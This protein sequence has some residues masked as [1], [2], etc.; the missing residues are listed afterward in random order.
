LLRSLSANALLILTY[1]SI[2]SEKEVKTV[3]NAVAQARF[4]EQMGW[5]S[6]QYRCVTL[7]EAFDEWIQFG[8]INPRT[9]VVTFDDGFANNYENG[10]PILKEF[11]IRA[12]FFVTTG[13]LGTNSLPILT[14]ARILLQVAGQR[15]I[16]LNSND[17]E[18]TYQRL[19][20]A[21]KQE[22]KEIV[23]RLHEK[24]PHCDCLIDRE[25]QPYMSVDQLQDIVKDGHEIGSHTVTHL[26]LIGLTQDERDK[27][28]GESRRVLEDV[29]SIEVSS[30]CYPYGIFNT[31]VANQVRQSGYRCSVSTAWGLNYDLIDPYRLSR[32]EGPNKT[33]AEFVTKTAGAIDAIYAKYH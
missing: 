15:K 33:L 26:P 25:R 9:A 7:A 18:R 31:D 29:L 3:R 6:A 27:E 5:L 17:I 8:R 28:I 19:K 22:I 4:R 21:R 2:K 24:I 12:T 13:F 16:L 30:F 23:K 11:G 10:L 32:I 20:L 1:H 14:E